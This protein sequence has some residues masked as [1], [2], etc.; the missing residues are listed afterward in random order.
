M[1]K[2]VSTIIVITI[3]AIA[4]FIESTCYQPKKYLPKQN[5]VIPANQNENMNVIANDT[6]FYNYLTPP[7]VCL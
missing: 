3:K 1:N 2:P 7:S 6:V 4:I 5:P